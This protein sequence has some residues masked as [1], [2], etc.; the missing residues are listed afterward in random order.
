MNAPIVPPRE[1]VRWERRGEGDGLTNTVHKSDVQRV[2]NFQ[3][4]FE[5]KKKIDDQR[6]DDSEENGPA[7]L[8]MA[9]GGGDADETDDRSNARTRDTDVSPNGIDDRP[10]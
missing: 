9:T 1:L 2:V 7:G 3:M 6:W 8:D 10:S 4:M 5:E